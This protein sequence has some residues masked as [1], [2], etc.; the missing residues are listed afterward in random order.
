MMNTIDKAAVGWTIAI[1]AIG[2]I[3]AY[4]GSPP[5][6]PPPPIDI[7]GDGIDNNSN[8]EIDEGCST[9]N[10]LNDNDADTKSNDDDNCPE[11]PNT[12]QQDSDR[13]GVGNAC[14]DTPIGEEDE[15]QNDEITMENVINM[16]I[17]RINYLS[18]YLN[19]L[20]DF[21]NDEKALIKTTLGEIQS[22]IQNNSLSAYNKMY[23][24]REHFDGTGTDELVSDTQTRK[25][26]YNLISDILLS[27]EKTLFLPTNNHP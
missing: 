13:D 14:D 1:V 25:D 7:C 21:D 6:P 18:S 26:I 20:P 27:Q 8:G 22:D 10:P 24:F 2:L 16:R 23:Q 12:D 19:T 15:T 3:F 11:K 4:I 17:L 5:P 9:I